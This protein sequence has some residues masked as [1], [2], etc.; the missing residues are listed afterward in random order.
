MSLRS[1]VPT[2]GLQSHMCSSPSQ[3]P[4]QQGLRPGRQ[5]KAHESR[6]PLSTSQERKWSEG[7]S[8]RPWNLFFRGAGGGPMQLPP[9]ALFPCPRVG[10]PGLWMGEW[11]RYPGSGARGAGKP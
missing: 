11:G 9:N 3:A 8:D 10:L 1:P 4:V 7:V 6:L 5:R 2:H